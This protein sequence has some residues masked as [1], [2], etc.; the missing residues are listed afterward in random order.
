[1]KIQLDILRREAAGAEPYWQSFMYETEDENATAATALR[2]LE[3]TPEL[4]DIDGKPA[5]PVRWECSCMQKK[6]GACAMIINGKPVLACSYQLRQAEGG[7]VRLE[8][9][10]KFPV[11]ADLIADRTPMLE[12]LREMRLWLNERTKADETVNHIAYDASRCLQC[13]LCLEVC[14]NFYTGGR[15]PGMAAAVP[16]ARL[17]S[18]LPE[19]QQAELYRAYRRGIYEGCGKSMACRNVCPAG[20]DIEGLLV[21]SNAAAV[22]KR[23]IFRKKDSGGSR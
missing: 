7:K 12:A 15:F 13:G 18:V 20:I 19:S 3:T 17:I 8:P 2:E 10:S 9:L 23:R 14:P 22:W 1:M 21:S 4:R 11:I 6:C 16:A 5:A